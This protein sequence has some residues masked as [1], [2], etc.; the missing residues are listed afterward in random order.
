M[1]ISKTTYD[2]AGRCINGRWVD[3][4]CGVEIETEIRNGM[5]VY[6]GRLRTPS[7]EV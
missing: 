7:T 4:I 3:T 5:L 1:T 2:A 6:F